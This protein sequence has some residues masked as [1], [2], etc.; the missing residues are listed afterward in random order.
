MREIVP[1]DVVGIAIVDRNAS[2]T[3]RV[4]TRGETGD[5]A[6]EHVCATCA[7]AD[8]AAIAAH[9]DGL[10]I[11][12]AFDLPPYLAP[13][14]KRG[15]SSMLVLPIVSQHALVGAVV[16]GFNGKYALTDEERARARMLGDRVAV[17]FATATRDEELYYHANYDALTGLPNRLYFKDQLARRLAQ[18][19][20]E[21]TPFALLFIDLD[22]FKTIND[23]L[24]HAAGDEVLRQSAA[25]LRR[26]VRETDTVTRLGGDEFTII[27]WQIHSTRDPESAALNVVNALAPPFTI[28]GTEHRV[29]ASIGIAVYPDDGTSADELLRNADTA[30]YRAKESGRGRYVYFEER[31]NVAAHARVNLEREIKEALERGEFRLW[32]QPMLDMR[33]GRV[34]GA[35][36]VLGWERPGR[37]RRLP[38]DFFEIANETGLIEPIGEWMLTEGCRQ[39]QAWHVAGI[40]TPRV[41]LEV[42]ARQFRQR[43]FVEQVRRIVTTA[44]IA[45][46]CLE[47]E[48]NEDLLLDAAKG[49]AHMLDELRAIG[50]TF[51]LDDF[52]AGQASLACLNRFP[53]ENVK[54]D[55]S[56]TPEVG[57]ETGAGAM[58]AAIIATAHALNKR[59][60]ADGVTTEKQAALLGRLGC[61]QIQ[62]PY[63]SRALD[64]SRFG[65][66]LKDSA[67][68][69]ATRPA[70]LTKNAARA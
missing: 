51:C 29:S 30:M 39:F 62:G 27:L 56:L 3:M 48:I 1:A 54:I 5:G 35:E 21:S 57:G 66:F 49:T 44:G 37:E 22:R 13:V 14:A 16:L 10:W 17:A 23:K 12:R 15:A 9:A 59:V 64:A 26:C 46:Y 69:A 70:F 47:L 18:A 11:D 68:S 2:G 19:H 25:R 45:P 38:V 42:S 40:D 65:E 52:G 31:M 6:L 28:G 43:G 36:A 33:S 55:R 67:A 24:G 7:G 63:V 41:A 58:V 8:T 34:A 61:H 4:V 60:V 50:V 20:R 32:Y 53:V